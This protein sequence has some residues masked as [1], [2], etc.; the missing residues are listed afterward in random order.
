V[1]EE[2]GALE[3]IGPSHINADLTM[4]INSTV[5]TFQDSGAA[6]LL[7]T[8][9]EDRLQFDSVQLSLDTQTLA[10][11]SIIV[12][13]EITS[14]AKDDLILL[15]QE[16][17][18]GEF[19]P[20]QGQPISKISITTAEDIQLLIRSKQGTISLAVLFS[21]MLI[22]AL[23]ALTQSV[24]ARFDH[25]TKNSHARWDP[26][27]WMVGLTFL[28]LL[29]H[30]VALHIDAWRPV[31]L[32]KAIMWIHHVATALRQICELDCF[33]IQVFVFAVSV[34]NVRV[35]GSQGALGALQKY[36][37]GVN[38]TLTVTSSHAGCLCS[39]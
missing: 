23:V 13:I 16:F 30:C 7:K 17:L 10:T 36:M 14:V 5:E 25:S 19:Q 22:W 6:G 20:L 39:L 3:A 1:D 37:Y 35:T 31:S 24:K 2:I 29:G 18:R 34:H 38:A 32:S 21:V 8:E 15:K 9:L 12:H 33:S 28:V 4:C 26:S 27:D 11:E